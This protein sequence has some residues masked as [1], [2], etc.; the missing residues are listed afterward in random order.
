M[1][2]TPFDLTPEQ[3]GLLA[4]LASETGKSIP[5]LISE[6][7]E[8]LQEHM[9]HHPINGTPHDSDEENSA[10]QPPEVQKPL[11]EQICETFAKVPE[12]ELASLPDDGAAQVDHYAYG[13]PKR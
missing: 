11:W 8:G 12:D 4:A 2:T 3:K 13:L 1:E 6:A 10:P 5:A 9:R 7:L